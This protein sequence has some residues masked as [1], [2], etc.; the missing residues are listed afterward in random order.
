MT[1]Q[2]KNLVE[3][4]KNLNQSVPFGLSVITKYLNGKITAKMVHGNAEKVSVRV[5]YDH[6]L[7]TGE[8]HMYTALIL[9]EKVKAEHGKEFTIE[10]SSYNEKD[11]G[12][13]FITERID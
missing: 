13:A 4:A 1:T 10:M 6:G 5:S 3:Q 11:D 8:N 2:A 9:L 12:Y 7:S